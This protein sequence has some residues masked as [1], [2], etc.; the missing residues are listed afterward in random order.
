MTKVSIVAVNLQVTAFASERLWASCL[1]RRL[2][3][4][5]VSLPTASLGY[6]LTPI[7][8]ASTPPSMTTYPRYRPNSSG[9]LATFAGIR[10]AL[11]EKHDLD[12]RRERACPS[13]LQ[14]EARGI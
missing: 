11:V 12:Q 10:R 6:W 2:I 7:Y 5:S 8:F 14:R 3:R 9:S 1:G 13:I 4:T